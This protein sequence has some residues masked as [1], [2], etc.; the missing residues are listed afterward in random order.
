MTLISSR[1]AGAVFS[2]SVFSG[3][4]R[5]RFSSILGRTSWACISNPAAR[6]ASWASLDVRSPDTGHV[7]CASAFGK[8]CAGFTRTTLRG[9]KS[10]QALPRIGKRHARHLFGE[11]DGRTSSS[12]GC[13]GGLSARCGRSEDSRPLPRISGWSQR[14]FISGCSPIR[15]VSHQSSL[16]AFNVFNA[17]TNFGA[18]V[19]RCARL[20]GYCCNLWLLRPVASHS[21]LPIVF[22]SESHLNFIADAAKA[23]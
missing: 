21:R 18:K 14:H 19:P 2:G 23:F 15:S 5:G 10:S 1:E 13:P 9:C 16:V 20:G 11:Y 7:D 22:G 4:I 17:L 6:F 12:S 8:I 3:R